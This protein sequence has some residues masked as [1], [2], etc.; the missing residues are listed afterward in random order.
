MRFDV[1]RSFSAV[2]SACAFLCTA[3]LSAQDSDTAPASYPQIVRIS[4]AEGDVR[5]SRG[6]R[7][8]K[9]Y[10]G[11]SGQTTGWEQAGTGLSLASGYSL[12]TGT[13]RAEIELE[14]GSVVYLGEKS[15]LKFGELSSTAGVP[16]TQMALLSGTATL[17]LKLTDPGEHFALSTPTD[18]LQ[19]VYPQKAYL[20]VNSYLD[21]MVV[22]PQGDLKYMMDGVWKNQPEGRSSAFSHGQRI[23][24]PPQAMMSSYATWDSWVDT[25]VKTRDAANAEALKESGLKDPLPGLAAL[26]GHGKFF[27]CQPHGTCWEPSKGWDGKGNSSASNTAPSS[28]SATTT[29]TSA[30]A[31]PKKIDTSWYDKADAYEQAHPHY[32]LYTED[33]TFPCSA[34]VVQD[35]VARDPVTGKEKIINSRFDPAYWPIGSHSPLIAYSSRWNYW[36]WGYDM[37]W[38]QYPWQWTV[39]HAG[40]WIRWQHQYVWVVGRKMHHQCPVRWVKNGHSVGYVPIHPHDT[41]GRP[42]LNLKNGL[43]AVS[44]RKAGQLTR[45]EL[46][47]SK[48]VKVLS[49]PPK[50]FRRATLEPL[51]RVDAPH[52]MGRLITVAAESNHVTTPLGSTTANGSPAKSFVRTEGERPIEFNRKSQGFAVER[53]DGQHR[54]PPEVMFAGRPEAI[55][56]HVEHREGVGYA[57]T[58]GPAA[59][60]NFGAAASQSNGAVNQGRSGYSPNSGSP[61]RSP[62]GNTGFSHNGGAA[63]SGANSGGSPHGA[64]GGG[65]GGG[66]GTSHSGGGSGSSGGGASAPSPSPSAPSAPSPAPSAPSSPSGRSR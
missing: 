25:R 28:E 49:E 56:S 4:Y 64:G 48:S 50:E 20:R 14:D 31:K 37:Y 33:Y 59:R 43:I 3:T 24:L 9:L 39:C 8:D 29:A 36:G 66:G 35:L 61:R 2:L 5:V 47:P 12:V 60:G 40:S 23:L 46:D 13:G 41:P 26:T 58:V 42:P 21:A 7:A 18:G 34:Y 63:G 17:D 44:D 32:Y 57:N 62:A 55:Q 22:T 45:I 19:L 65:S 54:H 11:Q 52:P 10:D 16:F 53:T 38:D 6:K 30:Q 27:N 1:R 51:T 15:V